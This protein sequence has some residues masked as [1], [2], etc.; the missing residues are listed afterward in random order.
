MPKTKQPKQRK[1]LVNKCRVCQGNFE[2]TRKDAKTC[3][4]GCRQALHQQE[5]RKRL[6]T[7]SI[8]TPEEL[9]AGIVEVLPKMA[10]RY[11]SA[12]QLWVDFDWTTIPQRQKDLMELYA[13]AESISVDTLQRNFEQ[14][15]LERMGVE[16]DQKAA[17]RQEERQALVEKITEIQAE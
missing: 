10:T 11:D 16:I 8:T 1:V 17:D 2:S 3:S 13:V 4:N 15:L 12:G 9:K 5:L 14:I 7:Y 6:I